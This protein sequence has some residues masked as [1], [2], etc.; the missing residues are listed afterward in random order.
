MSDKIR[1]MILLLL[2]R[3][4]RGFEEIV[5]DSA[6]SRGAVNKYLSQLYKEGLVEQESGRGSR[7]YLLTDKGKLEIGKKLF[8]EKATEK[9]VEADNPEKMRAG[10]VEMKRIIEE[11]EKLPDSDLPGF[12]SSYAMIGEITGFYSFKPKK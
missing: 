7:K 10:L 4:R 2:R 8:V 9:L 3:K 5:N 12:L 1:R 6:F 11:A